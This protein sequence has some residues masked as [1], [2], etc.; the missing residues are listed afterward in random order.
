MTPAVDASGRP[1]PLVRGL[2]LSVLAACCY[3][4]LPVIGKLGY[5]AGLDLGGMLF[6]RFTSAALFVG[7]Y[8]LATKPSRILVDRGTLLRAALLGGAVYPVQSL[9]FFGAVAR[10]PA[11]TTTLIFYGYPLAVTLLLWLVERQRPGRNVWLSLALIGAG[12]CLVFYNAFLQRAEPLGMLLAAGSMAIFSVYMLLVQR[13]LWG[14]DVLSV[15]FWVFVFAALSFS[16]GALPGSSLF[17]APAEAWFM[18]A[19]VGLVPTALSGMLLYAAIG[20]VGS[21]YVALFASLEPGVTVLAAWLILGEPVLPLK[22]AGLV[23]IIAGILLPNL[24]LLRQSGRREAMPPA[25]PM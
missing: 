1:L 6:L 15:I 10:I 16:L 9:C 21:A 4:F 8:F 2:V 7:L 23:L 13:F 12:I 5:A 17:S 14:R 11:S 24:R 22:L 19:L 20:L 25:G 3:G 18:G